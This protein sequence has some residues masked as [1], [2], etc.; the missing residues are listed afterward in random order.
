MST[1]ICPLCRYGFQNEVIGAVDKLRNQ[2]SG[3]RPDVAGAF[4]FVRENMFIGSNG[5]RPRARN[6]VVLLTGRFP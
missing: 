4:D 6:F 1:S 5:D 2:P 3:A